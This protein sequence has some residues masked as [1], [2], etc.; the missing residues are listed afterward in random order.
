M[1][2]FGTWWLNLGYD[3]V[4]RLVPNPNTWLRVR[5]PDSNIVS[6]NHSPPKQTSGSTGQIALQW[7]VTSRSSEWVIRVLENNKGTPQWMSTELYFIYPKPL[8]Q[9][10]TLMTFLRDPELV[11]FRGKFFVI[12]AGMRLQG[13]K[14]WIWRQDPGGYFTGS[15]GPKILWQSSLSGGYLASRGIRNNQYGCHC[16]IQIL[17]WTH[18][19][20]T[21]VCP[22]KANWYVGPLLSAGR[23]REGN[24]SFKEIA[25]VLDLSGRLFE[26]ASLIFRVH[27]YPK[28]ILKGWLHWA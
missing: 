16:M 18:A 28:L 12:C 26:H 11:I 27:V 3:R 9:E 10:A 21:K 25:S 19:G 6:A 1:N 17:W 4:D 2:D 22:Q 24:N 14:K 7:K 20:Q 5:I 8:Q 13:Y 23:N 15:S